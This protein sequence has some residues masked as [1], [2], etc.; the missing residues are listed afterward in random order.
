MFGH[1]CNFIRE[2]HRLPTANKLINPLFPK[3]WAGSSGGMLTLMFR[4]L[5]VVATLFEL[6]RSYRG[7]KTHTRHGDR[8]R[9]EMVSLKLLLSGLGAL[10]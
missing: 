8:T 9:Q 5:F 7:L 4:E 3:G 2:C 1:Y 6:L 10:V